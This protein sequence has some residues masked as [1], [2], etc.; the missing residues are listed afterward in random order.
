MNQSNIELIDT[1]KD[2]AEL[3]INGE[4]VDMQGEPN[5]L[6]KFVE[7][8]LKYSHDKAVVHGNRAL[9]YLDL[10][11]KANKI[12]HYIIGRKIAPGDIVGI[13]IDRSL[14]MI[15]SIIGIL[16]AGAVYAP[17]DTSYPKARILNMISSNKLDLLITNGNSINQLSDIKVPIINYSDEFEDI[18]HCKGTNPNIELKPNALCY[19]IYTSGTTGVPKGAGVYHYGWKNLLKWFKDEFDLKK[20]HKNLIV[21]SISFDI[22][23]RAIMMTL[24]SGG[25]L[26]L[27]NS[28]VFDPVIVKDT[29]CQEGIS[30]INTTPSLFYTLIDDSIIENL[31]ELNSLKYIFLGGEPING[32]RLQHY[33]NI[34]TNK[35]INVYGSAECTDVS[36]YHIVESSDCLKEHVPVGKPIYN[37]G[38]CILDQNNIIQPKNTVGEI[39]IS[40]IGLGAGYLNSDELTKEKFFIYQNEKDQSLLLYKTGDRGRILED[41]NLECFGRTDLMTKLRG[42]RVDLGEIESLLKENEFIEEAIVY[43]DLIDDL[44]VLNAIVKK[45]KDKI[46]F[47]LTIILKKYLKLQLPEYMVPNRFFYINYFPLSSN[48][49]IPKSAIDKGFITKKIEKPR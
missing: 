16:K 9:T 43:V 25:E 30:I 32:K 46:D 15:I 1:K 8:V 13:F 40:G 34:Q 12:A 42:Y 10:N 39:A 23:Q 21:S 20:E 7:I 14:E 4:F 11:K 22:T 33:C 44:Q 41:D 19:L 6:E 17:I 38:F 3:M 29:I 24:T 35:I 18:M 2:V 5:V 28:D 37:T 27:L 48:G 26:H 47:D 36:T 49:K 45:T 31:E